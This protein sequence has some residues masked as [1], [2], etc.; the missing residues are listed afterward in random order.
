MYSVNPADAPADFGTVFEARDGYHQSYKG[1]ELVATK[2][3]ANNWM[4]RVAYSTGSNR[5]YFDN[6][7][8]HADPTPTL[9]GTSEWTLG[10]PNVDGGITFLPSSGS[11]KSNIFIT[12]P[13]YQFVMTGAYQMKWDVTLGVNYLLR[14]GSAAPFYYGSSN[15]ETADPTL[16]AGGRNIVVVPVEDYHLPAVNSF[17]FR[18]SKALNYKTFTA[19]IDFDIFN[20][21]NNATQLQRQFDVTAPNLNN[22]LE[23]MNPRILR[24]GVRFGFK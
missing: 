10:S 5:E 7:D 17:D 16:A 11:G 6:I 14:Q 24:I 18:V 4:A 21:F 20:L 12:T 13:T 15:P 9:P 2:R 23:I 8:A 3:M 1:L 22:V 19:N